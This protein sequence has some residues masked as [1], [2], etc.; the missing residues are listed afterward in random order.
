MSN[1]RLA[2][3]TIDFCRGR[4]RNRKDEYL[5]RTIQGIAS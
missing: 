3:E 1:R 5:Q 2:V 4:K